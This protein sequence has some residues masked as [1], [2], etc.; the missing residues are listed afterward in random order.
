MAAWPRGRTCSPTS[1]TRT[2]RSWRIGSARR[3]CCTICSRRAGLD[4]DEFWALDR[5]LRSQVFLG[6]FA[7]DSRAVPSLELTAF[8][9]DKLLKER[10]RREPLTV[11]AAWH[12]GYW[13]SYFSHAAITHPANDGLREEFSTA[14]DIV[15]KRPAVLYREGDGRRAEELRA[16]RVDLPLI[17]GP[18]PFG[19]G[20]RLELAYLEAIAQADPAHDIRSRSLVVIEADKAAEHVAELLPHAADIVVRLAPRHIAALADGATSG[21]TGAASTLEG[22]SDGAALA[23]LVRAARIVELDPW[24]DGRGELGTTSGAASGTA[25]EAGIACQE[26][27]RTLA[28]AA[29]ALNPGAAA[30][31]PHALR[32]R[33]LLGA[34]RGGGAPRGRRPDPL[35]DRGAQVVPAHAQGRRLPQ[36]E[37]AARPRAAGLRRRRHRHAG[38]GGDGLRGRPAGRQRRRDDARRRHRARARDRRRARRRRC[39]ARRRGSR[40]PRSRRRCARWRCARSPAGSTASSTSS[41]AWASTTCRRRAAT[42]WRSPSRRTGSA[43]SMPSPRTSSAAPT[44]RRTRRAWRP[45]RLPRRCASGTASRRCSPNARPICRWSTRRAC[46]PSATPTTTSRTQAGRSTPTSSRSSTAWRRGRCPKLDDFFVAGDQ[47]PYSLDRV[48]LKLSKESVAWSLERL[49]R[50]PAL[51]DYIQLAVPR[52]FSRPGAAAPGASVSVHAEPEG[53]ALVRVEADAR[54]GFELAL[55]PGHLLEDALDGARQADDDGRRR[56]RP[57][58]RFAVA[59]GRRPGRF[60]GAHGADAGGPRRARRQRAARF[61]RRDGRAQARPARRARAERLRRAR[62]HLAH[63]REP[64]LH[65]ARRRQRGLPH[66]AHRGQRR[67]RHDLER[68]RR[69]DPALLS[70]GHEV[71]EPPG[72]L[73]PLRPH[74]R[75]PAQGPRRRDQDQPGRQARQGRPP[76]RRQGHAHGEQGAQHPRGHR[77]ARA[78][79]QARHLLDRGHA[80]RGLALAALPQPLRHQDHRLHLHAL[81]RRRHVEQLRRRLPA[82]RRRDG[83]LGQLPRRLE[84]RGLAGHLPHDAAHAPRADGRAGRPRGERRAAADPRPQRRALRGRRRHAPVRL[85]RPARRARHAQGADRRRRRPARGQHRQGRRLRLHAVRQLPPRLP[86][87][88]HHHQAGADGPERPRADGPALPQLVRAQLGQAGGPDRRAQPRERGARGGRQRRRAARAARRH[89][90]A[91]WP[92]RSARDAGLGRRRREGDG[93][94]GEM[95]QAEVELESSDARRR[96]RRSTTPAASARSP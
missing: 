42:R 47:G 87:R 55:D 85:R 19:G 16:V 94:G 46:S 69:P 44:P 96:R 12:H 63:R 75:R 80:G 2:R 68:R 77:R 52:G 51:L 90:Q 40:T 17:V 54:G 3:R 73:R 31:R 53:P 22:A 76:G 88:R 18:L 49:R 48:G 30:Q 81:R 74:R 60:R 10:F 62:A 71:G 21:V 70:R 26:A 79:P 61:R 92:H 78:R 28:D 23:E 5:A 95:S 57:R 56:R 29:L 4:E 84:P 64:R 45:S 39:G 25:L 89:P 7:G 6:A 32:R 93:T 37:A 38:L 36:A 86:A 65:V 20:L 27:L 66:G 24:R 15:R 33:R 82:R 58:R 13:R 72:R 1:S 91:A 41:A 8:D 59:Q 35:P 83:R 43:R 50:D 9:V 34:P 67:H 14:W 11:G